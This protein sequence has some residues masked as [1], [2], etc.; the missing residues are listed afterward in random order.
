[1]LPNVR[2][3]VLAGGLLLLGNTAA[4]EINPLHE[5]YTQNSNTP[6]GRAFD[7]V[8]EE[9]TQLARACQLAH[10]GPVQ[11]PLVCTDRNTRDQE[12]RGNKYDSLVRGVWWNDDPNQLLFAVRQG[13]FW[14][15]MRDARRIA[16]TNHNWKGKPAAID[17]TYYMAYRSHYG[18]LQFLHA[19]AS[20]NGEPARDTQ[21]SILLWAEFAYAVA[22]GRVD[23][24]TKMDR[25][26]PSDLQPYFRN[27]GGWTVNY[28]FAPR[29]RLKSASHIRS[30]AAGSLLHMV[31]DSYSAA[32]ADRAFEAS[33]RCP[34]GSVLEFHS[35]TH[36]RPDL[37]QAVDRRTAWQARTFT[38]AQDPVNVSATLLAYI[39][40][41]ADWNVVR[42]Y[43]QGTVFCI[44]EGAREAGPGGFVVATTG[45]RS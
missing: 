16:T 31:Q 29:Y 30:M 7:A 32:H 38:T 11:A 44:D 23:L 33:D 1:M 22:T 13:K 26:P 12:A 39:A 41:R 8:H 17:G 5:K 21:Q 28:L 6:F 42:D 37:H 24:E 18:D 45:G 25:V 34:T 15:W 40:Q 10:P 2:V 36:Q 14:A 43:L 27:Q 19:M 4:H 9:I 35:Y 20:R 3:A